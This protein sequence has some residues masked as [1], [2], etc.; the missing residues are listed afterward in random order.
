MTSRRSNVIVGSVT[1]GGVNSF[2]YEWPATLRALEALDFDRV[3]PGHGSVQE[4]KSVPAE[5]RG[6]VEE[7]TEKVTRGVERGQ[8]LDEL[9]KTITPGA[10]AS[11]AANNTRRRVER[12]LGVLFT[13]SKPG[14]LLDGGVS[15]NVRE[16]F[17]Y[18]T[19]RKGKH[20]LPLR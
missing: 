12:E 11:L 6:Y 13:P 3:I 8:P 1:R 20:E 19:E 9:R 15:G 7:V 10:L 17:T 5:F 16:V 14:E 4:G 18:L 2:W